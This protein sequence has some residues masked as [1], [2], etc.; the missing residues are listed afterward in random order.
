MAKR[1]IYL[2]GGCFWGL[3]KLMRSLPGVTDA[4]SGYANGRTE[5][6]TYQEVCGGTTGHRETVR[7]TYDPEKTSLDALLFAYFSVIDPTTP[8]RQGHDTGTQYQTGI[9]TVDE[10]SRRTVERI[11]EIE[12]QNHERFCVEIAP[13]TRFYP[14]EEYHQRYLEKNPGGY[15]HILPGEIRALAR[16]RIDPGRYARPP[17]EALKEKLTPE[18]FAVTQQGATEAPFQNAYW[19]HRDR[20]IY[21]DAATG[22]PLF[23]STDKFASACGWPAFSAPIDPGVVRYKEDRSHGMRRVE[24]R[25]RAGGSHLGHVFEGESD[26]PGGVRYCINSAALRFIPYD[27]MDAAGYGD[28]KDL[29]K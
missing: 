4:V 15:C 26:A 11:V 25:S 3:E 17:R 12:R 16:A 29:V 1:V 18:Q 19:S 5:N 21:V 10:E 6:P 7:V 27:E 28:L 13:L 2:A 22:E 23:S 24:V 9:Y 8:D 20:G 14:A